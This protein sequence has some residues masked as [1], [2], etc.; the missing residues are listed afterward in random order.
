MVFLVN[1]YLVLDMI[2]EWG[3]RLFPVSR[4]FV[5]RSLI[6]F[7]RNDYL[8][9][10]NRGANFNSYEYH[11]CGII[12]LQRKTPVKICWNSAVTMPPLRKIPLPSRR[13]WSSLWNRPSGWR[14]KPAPP[15]RVIKWRFLGP[16]THGLPPSAP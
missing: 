4:K 1:H 5:G 6:P 2:N 10:S 15:I 3:A 8:L 7:S 9:K 11:F 14:K 16:R 13:S 12:H